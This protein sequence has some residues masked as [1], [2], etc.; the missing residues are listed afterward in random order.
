MKTPVQRLTDGLEMNG[1]DVEAIHTRDLEWWAD[2][3]W[4]LKSH[5]TPQGATACI[6]FLVDPQHEGL[7]NK[8]QAV[9]GVGCSHGFP[10]S[11][12]EAE[13]GGTISLNA[14]SRQGVAAFLEQVDRCRSTRP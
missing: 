2:E 10:V 1:W 13:A 5:W 9:W 6:T 3:I 7:R 14:L 11:K 4:E 8:G 12:R